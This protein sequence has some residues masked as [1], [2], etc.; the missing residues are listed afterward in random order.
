MKKHINDYSNYNDEQLLQILYDFDNIYSQSEK[1]AAHNILKQRNFDFEKFQKE[2]PESSK[3]IN[4]EKIKN[5]VE[6]SLHKVFIKKK[7]IYFTS[8]FILFLFLSFF[9]SAYKVINSIYFNVFLN[10]VA[11]MF[12]FISGLKLS[13]LSRLNA[14]LKYLKLNEFEQILAEKSLI[15][16]ISAL[17]KEIAI[18]KRQ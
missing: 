12:A 5:F 16:A 18:E 1:K 17:K 2:H 15:V 11:Y 13:K 3:K 6:F 8:G 4:K 9:N 10:F 7:L 14:F